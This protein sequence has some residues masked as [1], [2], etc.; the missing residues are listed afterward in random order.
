MRVSFT[1]WV[2]VEPG[3]EDDPA[4]IANYVEVLQSSEFWT[5]VRVTLTYAASSISCGL[6]VGTCF[7]LL[8]NL[9]FFWRTFFRSAMT[10]CSGRAVLFALWTIRQLAPGGGCA[11]LANLG[12]PP[13]R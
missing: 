9:E 10:P 5:A 12:T 13:P 4:G 8:L 2:L 11:A 1:R 6:V 7:A 3:S